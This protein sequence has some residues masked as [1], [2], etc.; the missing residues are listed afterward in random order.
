MEKLE[1]TNKKM[2]KFLYE[3]KEYDDLLGSKFFKIINLSNEL[4]I[5]KSKISRQ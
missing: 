3:S 5:N 2:A 4:N 1:S